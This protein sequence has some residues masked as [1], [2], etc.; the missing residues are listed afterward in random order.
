MITKKQVEQHNREPQLATL[1]MLISA[2]HKWTDTQTVLSFALEQVV[3]LAKAEAGECHLVNAHGELEFTAHYRLDSDFA[4]AS[5]SFRFSS[6]EGIP[7]WAYARQKAVYVPRIEAED[8]YQRKELAVKAGYRSLVCV[9]LTGMDTLLGTFILYYRKNVHPINDKQEILT[10]LGQQMGIAI[11]RA[12]LFQQTKKQVQELQILQAVTSALNRSSNIQE[13][14]ERSLEAVVTAMGLPSGWVVLMESGLGNRIAASYNVPSDLSLE[15]GDAMQEPCHCLSLLQCGML[16]SAMNILECQRLRNES[17]PEYPFRHHASI[18]LRA[19]GIILGNLNLV[20]S[21][22]RVFL[23]DELRMLTVIGDQIGVAIGR[24]MLYEESRERRSREQQTLLDHSRVLLGKQDTQSILD[25]TIR[26]AVGALQVNHAALALVDAGGNTYSIKAGYGR[27][28]ERLPSLQSLLLEDRT[29][30]SRAILGKAPLAISNMTREPLCGH[31]EGCEGRPSAMLVVPMLADNQ[32]LGAIS[33]HSDTPRE[34]EQDEIRFLS[35][36]ANQTA[37]A[38]ENARLFE[39]ERAAREQSET[40]REVAG[41]VS[42]SLELNVVLDLILVQLKRILNY[43]TASVLLMEASGTTALITGSGYADEKFTSQMSGQLLKKSPILRQMTLDLQPVIIADVREHPGWIWVPGAEHVRSFLAVPI[44]ARERMIGAMMMDSVEI[45]FFTEEITQSMQALVSHMAVAIENARLFETLR[46]EQLNTTQLY[47][48]SLELASDRDPEEVARRALEAA[49]QAIGAQKGNILTIE[50]DSERLQLLAVTGYDR[51][52]VEKLNQQLEWDT[53]KG[54]TGRVVRTRKATIVPDVAREPDWVPIPGLDDWVQSMIS[55]PLVTGNTVIGA[56]NLL[57]EKSDFF[58]KENLA[59]VSAIASPV[60]LALQNSSLYQG[61]QQRLSELEILADTSSILRKTHSPEEMPSILLKQAIKGLNADAGVLL[62]LENDEAKCAAVHK[63]SDVRAGDTSPRDWTIIWQVLE[64]G[65]P[66]F[67][68][69]ITQ[70]P[71]LHQHAACQTLMGESLSCVCVPLQLV[72]ATIGIILLNWKNKATLSAEELRLLESLAEIAAN[73]IHR[74][75]LHRQTEQQALELTLAYDTTIEGWSRALDLRDHET[76]GHTL[77]VTELTLELAR[78]MGI[79]ESDLLHIRR[80][81]LLHDIGKLG[82]P[83]KILHK[84]GPLNDKEREVICRHPQF[85]FD[86][87]SHISYL[88]PALAI[89]WCHHEKWDG[90]GYPCGLKGEEI[91][92]AA[93]IF[94]VVDV[95]DALTSDRPY[96][97]A[98]TR[99]KA[100]TY[101]R[102][103][104]GA[105]FD[106]NVVK[107][108][109]RMK[110]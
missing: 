43:D 109:L 3:K 19:G 63:V 9:P 96:R 98:W 41:T 64:N 105:H 47:R 108:F 57:S 62:L 101:I 45:G 90:S 83:D 69:N 21:D 46:R 93:R 15:D 37:S 72:E 23:D 22:D 39:S 5:A 33:V 40:L 52:S 53:S 42:K 73:A 94:A 17:R 54:V 31:G 14:L 85:A 44:I 89:P 38:I 104:A 6:G 13:A 95:F 49:A 1:N 68:P 61:L 75:R 48:L 77:R 24:A 65:K 87:L 30:I 34:W 55:V 2:T 27:P 74:S 58:S 35:L 60:A 10:V 12:H 102:R 79:P 91:P 100:L 59:L 81:S 20:V 32:S 82:V 76:E 78:E 11:E 51:N 66:R 4:A 97:S 28:A 70:Y 8:R 106:P 67:I 92:L 18:P 7:G 84:P 26:V 86:M 50:D 88:Q 80:G 99:K 29:P 103:Q 36:L 56:L 71:D 16:T 110:G 25:H 107:T